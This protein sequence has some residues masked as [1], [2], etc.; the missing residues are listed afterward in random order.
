MMPYS[1]IKHI[2]FWQKIYLTWYSF[3]QKTLFQTFLRIVDGSR[4]DLTLH[5]IVNDITPQKAEN[6]GARGK[7]MEDSDLDLANSKWKAENIE[8]TQR[9]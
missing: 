8:A 4:L 6:D 3:D 7:K 2:L 9:F 5:C 1:L